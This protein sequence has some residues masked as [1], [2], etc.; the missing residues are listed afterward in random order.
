MKQN[1]KDIQSAEVLLDFELLKQAYNKFGISGFEA[2]RLEATFAKCRMRTEAA[3]AIIGGESDEMTRRLFKK[4]L[5]YFP[6]KG[7]AEV[8]SKAA[9]FLTIHFTPVVKN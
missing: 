5:I 8:T 6:E 9:R 7:P 3:K 4:G 1:P 2:I